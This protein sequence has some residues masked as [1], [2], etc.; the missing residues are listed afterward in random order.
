[1]ATTRIDK[2]FDLLA[3][4]SRTALI[5]YIMAGD[6]QPD[7]TVPLMQTLVKSGGDLIELGVPFSDPMADGPIIQAAGERALRHHVSLGDVIGMVAEFR[8]SD[9]DT[10]V[11][12]MTYQNPI[13]AMGEAQFVASA[14]AAGVD[15]VLV[16][17]LPIEEADTLLKEVEGE[18][19]DIIF[20]TS[21]TTSVERL[22]RIAEVARGFIYY[23]SLKGVTGAKHI[24][25]EQIADKVKQFKNIITIPTAVGFG[26]HDEQSAKRV[27]QLADAVVVGSAIV[28][29]V[30]QNADANYRQRVADFVVGLRSA[31]DEKTS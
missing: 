7:A 18:A 11:V 3:A 28:R 13:E 22:K 5:P 6:P 29:I 27:A 21:P 24:E 15:G 4:A 19:L 31:I 25:L 20:L 16:V 1:M 2:R 30:E 10:P 23:V 17:D 26:I 8:Q 9:G 14:V 12:L